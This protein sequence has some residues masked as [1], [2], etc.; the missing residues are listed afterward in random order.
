MTF[1]SLNGT[2]PVTDA[3]SGYL[4]HAQD[5]LR[6]NSR[7][8]LILLINAPVIVV[9]LNVLRQLV[10]NLSSLLLSRTEHY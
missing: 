1:S 6:H 5:H 7:L 8:A 9:L 4:A 2:V 10:S 3:W